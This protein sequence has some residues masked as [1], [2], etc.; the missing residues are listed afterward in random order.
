VRD[1]FEGVPDDG[2]IITGVD[3]RQVPPASEPVIAAAIRAVR[4]RAKQASLHLYGSVATGQA[5]IGSPM[6]TC[7]ASGSLPAT[8]RN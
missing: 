6:S 3:R 7:S 2:M 4:E 5:R 8:R 1:V